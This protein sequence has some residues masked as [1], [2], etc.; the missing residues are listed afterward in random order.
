[1]VLIILPLISLRLIGLL[2]ILRERTS[3]RINDEAVRRKRR[4][5]QLIQKKILLYLQLRYFNLLLLYNIHILRNLYPRLDTTNR[6]SSITL[7]SCNFSIDVLRRYIVNITIL[8]TIIQ[9]LYL[10]CTTRTPPVL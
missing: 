4:Q 3:I 8:T 9:L 5:L 6:S 1:L 2:A 7:L 10:D